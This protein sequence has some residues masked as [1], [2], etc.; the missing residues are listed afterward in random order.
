VQPTQQVSLLFGSQE[1]AVDL[2]AAANTQLSFASGTLVPDKSF[3]RLRVDGVDS[4]LIVY[5]N[6]KPSGFDPK[7]LVTIT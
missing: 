6:R 7:R 4:Q 1:V 5:T 2:L 3:V